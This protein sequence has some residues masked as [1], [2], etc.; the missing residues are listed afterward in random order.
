M[1]ALVL[2]ERE[3][4]VAFLTLNRPERHNSLVPELLTGLLAALDDLRDRTELRAVVLQAN[5]RSFSTGGDMRAFY[6]H[7][8]NIKTYADELVGLLNRAILSLIALP[9][10]IVAAVHGTVTGGSLGLVLACD[11]VLVT[12]EATFTPYYSTVGYSPDGGWTALLPDLIGRGRTAAVL[13]T[14]RTI[15]AEEAVAWG[16]AHR[17]VASEGLQ[18]EARALAHAMAEQAAGSM[19]RAKRLL[20]G[21]EPQLA[22]RLEAERQQFVEQIATA[23]ARKGIVAFVERRVADRTWLKPGSG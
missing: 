12:P 15:S 22:A 10:P 9:L 1:D 20:W 17:L 5:G 2:T 7:L 11:I 4:A 23:E 16:I 18:T 19:R 6:D 21:D 8:P 13:M 3:G 14:N